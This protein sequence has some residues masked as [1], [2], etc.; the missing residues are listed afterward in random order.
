MLARQFRLRQIRRP[1]KSAG[2]AQTFSP[3]LS[4]LFL[5]GESIPIFTGTRA[6]GRERQWRYGLTVC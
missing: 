4:A 1:D 6:T 3:F 2:G 5:L